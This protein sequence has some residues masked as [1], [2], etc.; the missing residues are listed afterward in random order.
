VVSSQGSPGLCV[1]AVDA[2]LLW[3]WLYRSPTASGLII[4]VEEKA[5]P[6]GVAL[7]ETVG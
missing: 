7:R 6:L 1:L 4:R 3:L 2:L 5:P